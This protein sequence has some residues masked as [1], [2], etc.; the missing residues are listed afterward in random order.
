[1]VDCRQIEASQEELSTFLGAR[2]EQIVAVFEHPRIPFISYPY[3]WTFSQLKDAALTHLDLQLIAFE[4]GF[5]LSDATA[6]NIQFLSGRPIHI[7]CMSLRRY[8]EGQVWEGYNQ[9]CRQ[10]LLPLLIEAWSGCAFQPMLRGSL[11]GISFSDALAILPRFQLFTSPSALMHVYLHGKAINTKSASATGLQS[12]TKLRAGSYKAIL[13]QLRDFISGLKSRKRPVSFWNDYAFSNSYSESMR[14]T[15][16]SFVKQWAASCKPKM[17]LDIGGNTGDY[18]LAAVDGGADSCVILDSDL[19][20]V[21][22]AYLRFKNSGTQIFPLLMNF[23]DPTPDM[24]WRQCERKGIESRARADGVIA[25]ALIHHLVISGNVPLR[26]AVHWIMGMA[27]KGIIE[28][29]PKQDPM[30]T[31]LL[32]TREDIYTDYTEEMFREAVT[33][34]GRIVLEHSIEENGRLLAAYETL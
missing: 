29:V 32:S 5:V 20:S 31:G 3:E 33:A 21:D 2:G 15:K 7:D 11:E 17:L 27:P 18:S 34:R 4:H 25:L 9:F 12:A 19:D 26:D 10:F 8:S 1:M 22:I 6:Y 14:R 24:G 16:L 28:F 23:L 13:K 30:V